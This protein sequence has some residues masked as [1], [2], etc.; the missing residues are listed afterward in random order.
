LKFVVPSRANDSLLQLPKNLAGQLQIWDAHAMIPFEKL[1]HAAQLKCLAELARQSL[2]LYKLAQAT[3]LKLI[4]L[5]ENATFRL[6]CADGARFAL[7]IHREGY[8]TREAIASELAW[9][10][11]LRKESVAITPVPITG[12]NGDLIQHVAHASMPR[13]RHVVLF[14]WEEGA[15]PLIT[16]DLS[17]PF[18]ILGETAARMH[19]HSRQ[20]KKPLW[21][22]RHV[23]NFETALGERAP[24]WGHWRTGLGVDDKIAKVFE[25]TVLVIG[26]RLAAYGESRE[27]FGLVHADIRLAN[28]LVHNDQVKVLDFDDCGFSW[29]MYD[30][31]TT[32][33]F[34][35]H[36]PQVPDLIE[37]W[38]EGYRRVAPLSKIDEAEIPTFLMLRR[39]LLVAWL[40][41]HREIELARQLGSDYARQSVDLC[42]TFL[43]RNRM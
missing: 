34:Y 26:Q 35:E 5:S 29:F 4:N 23:W 8:H 36:E 22:T 1:D 32:V 3:S 24:H 43:T 10:I 12:S 19:V 16:G 38:K 11:D 6:D 14:K 39:L 2:P 31:A 13:G 42:E 9:L 37:S 41:T 18:A 15:E 7:R 21:F 20:W 28:L 25:R 27:N 30:A 33:S 40:G 17:K